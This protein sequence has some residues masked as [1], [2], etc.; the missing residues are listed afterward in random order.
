MPPVPQIRFCL[1]LLALGWCTGCAVERSSLSIDSNS[2]VPFLGMQ[3][4]PAKKKEP[5][6]QKS[7]SRGLSTKSDAAVVQLAVEEP[8]SDT[9]WADWLSPAPRVSQPL[10]RTDQQPHAPAPANASKPS[11]DAIEF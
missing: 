10:P 4:A 2:R 1:V 7:I 5:V 3:L 6:Y 8:R 11:E 9:H